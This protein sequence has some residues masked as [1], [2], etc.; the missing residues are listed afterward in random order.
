VRRPPIPIRLAATDH[1]AP[2]D[3]EWRARKTRRAAREIGL[4]P[5]AFSGVWRRGRDDMAP[6]SQQLCE[7]LG[8]FVLPNYSSGFEMADEFSL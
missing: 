2:H 6:N 4:P 8:D 1:L 3:I 7:C 5:L